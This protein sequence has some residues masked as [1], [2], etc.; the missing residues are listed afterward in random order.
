ME[1]GSKVAKGGHGEQLSTLTSADAPGKC[2]SCLR[3]HFVNCL[4]TLSDAQTRDDTTHEKST[5]STLTRL[6]A[7]MYMYC[8]PP[9]MSH[10]LPRAPRLHRTTRVFR[11]VLESRAG[12]RGSPMG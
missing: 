2:F 9:L 7:L 11:L 5:D 1:G 3:V 10:L 6:T 12:P 8:R 4:N